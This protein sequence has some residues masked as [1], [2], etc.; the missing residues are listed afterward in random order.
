MSGQ[1]ILF[2]IPDKNG[3]TWSLNPW[4]T[5]LALNFKGIDYKTEWLEYP[6]IEARLKPTGLEGDPDQIALFTCPTVQFPDGTYVM[7]SAK[8]I[9]RIEAE[10]PEPPLYHDLELTQTLLQSAQGLMDALAAILLPIAPRR[11]LSERSAKYFW[12]TRKEYLGMSLDEF[13][14]RYGGEKAWEK[15]KKPLD[16]ITALLSKTEGP[17]FL[18]DKVAYADFILVGF[19]FWAKKFD[20]EV[21][22]RITQHSDVFEKLYQACGPWL[23]RQD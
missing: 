23:E 8:I 4:K 13:E 14:E 18:G 16:E 6:D 12:E 19:L 5:R 3:E 11:I 21:Y 22:R 15:A 1:H 20:E 2:D 17:F 7:N 9:K 10:H